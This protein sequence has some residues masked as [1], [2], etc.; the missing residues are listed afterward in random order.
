MF[1]KLHQTTIQVIYECLKLLILKFTI[2]L[3]TQKASSSNLKWVLILSSFMG[4]TSR[5]WGILQG[6]SSSSY[7]F[8]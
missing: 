2:N 5:F 7:M 1:T 3:V 4:G 6:H 8:T